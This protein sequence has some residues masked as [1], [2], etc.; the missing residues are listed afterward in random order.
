MLEYDQAV[1]EYLHAIVRVR[2]WTLRRETEQLEALSDWLYAQSDLSV[3]LD[4]VT[5][6]VTHRYAAENNLS[7]AEREALDATLERLRA[8]TETYGL[9]DVRRAVALATR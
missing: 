8:W 7:D 2:P 3:E 9:R 5:P 1:D 4:A 6:E